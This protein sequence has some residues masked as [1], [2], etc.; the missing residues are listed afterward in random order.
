MIMFRDNKVTSQMR[1]DEQHRRICNLQANTDSAFV[2]NPSADQSCGDR[3]LG[4]ALPTKHSARFSYDTVGENG[5]TPH[6]MFRIAMHEYREINSHQT[7]FHEHL[8]WASCP[9]LRA[10]LNVVS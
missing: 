8:V 10:T 5:R 4:R 6:K 9:C 2:A 3:G 1:V 7:L